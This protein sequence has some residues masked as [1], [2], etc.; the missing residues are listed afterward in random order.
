ME[1]RNVQKLVIY[2]TKDGA[3]ELR[4]DANKENIWATQTDL[5]LIYQKD[6]SVISRHI[7]KNSKMEK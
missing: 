4:E 5:S 7:K 2:Q 3:L 6:Q 1:D